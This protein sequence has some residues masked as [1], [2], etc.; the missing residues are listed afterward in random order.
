MAEAETALAGLE[1]EFWAWRAAAQPD[2]PDDLNRV[3]HPPGWMPDWSPAAIAQRRCVIDGFAERHRALDLRGEPAAVQVD[4]SL[5]GCAVARARWELELLRAW[6]RDPSFYLAQSLAPV[7]N[8]LLVPPP[9]GEERASA[10]VRLLAHV[11]DVLEQGKQNLQGHAAAPFARH[12]VRLLMAIGERLEEAMAAL[13]AVLPAGQARALPGASRAA[14][15]A[16]RGY[17]DWLTVVLPGLDETTAVG[18]AALG[19]FLHRVALVPYPAEQLRAMAGQE[20]ARAV[21]A[22][23]ILRR[24]HRGRP[25][26]R[27][28]ASAA[29]VAARQRDD[30]LRMRRFYADRGLLSQPATLRHYRFAVMPDYLAPLTWLGVCDDLTSPSRAD[31]DALRYIREPS[32]Q[33]PYFELAKARDPFTAIVHEGVHAQQLALAW[34]N[35]DPARRH[36]YDSVP[37]EGIAFYNEELVALSG[38][39]DD[40]PDTTIFI[41]N[42][43]RLRALR[44]ETDIALALGDLTLGQAAGH[45]AR[46]VPL[47]RETAWQEAAFFAG[48]PGQGLSYQVGKLLILDLLAACARQLGDGFDLQAFHDR[49]WREGNVPLALQRFELLGLRDHLDEAER[50]AREE[51]PDEC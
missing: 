30:E 47:D 18:P 23:A 45:L 36:F 22:E 38:L 19:F 40:N 26:A 51:C 28:P 11:P 1:E 49:L 48:N 13:A 3:E 14:G 2:S 33:L 31:Q 27:L 35:P 43:M 7:Y 41:A 21:A 5:L 16:L 20:C 25:E 37:G 17:R 15:S 24:R 4:G 46:A 44:A 12:A 32:P 8:L 34:R 9:I 50:L 42:S 29:Q 10:I 39:F 6:Q